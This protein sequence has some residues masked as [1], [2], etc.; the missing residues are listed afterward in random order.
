MRQVW[1]GRALTGSRWLLGGGL[2]DSRCQD[3]EPVGKWYSRGRTARPAFPFKSQRA[4]KGFRVTQVMRYIPN[5]CFT[6]LFGELLAQFGS[7]CVQQKLAFDLLHSVFFFS[8]QYPTLLWNKWPEVM[9]RLQPDSTTFLSP[10]DRRQHC[11]PHSF[12]SA[13]DQWQQLRAFIFFGVFFPNIWRKCQA[14]K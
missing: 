3:N 12:S 13:W 4:I 8:P 11:T 9:C 6:Y 1:S 5:T 2:N 7:D 10:V 14:Q